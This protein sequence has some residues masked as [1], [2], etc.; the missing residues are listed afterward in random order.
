MRHCI[1]QTSWCGIA[2]TKHFFGN[3]TVSLTSDTS[4]R[5]VWMNHLE[6]SGD[7]V[8]HVTALL[9]PRV[10]V[11]HF[12]K[13]DFTVISDDEGTASFNGIDFKSVTKYQ[14][15]DTGNSSLTAPPRP[16]ATKSLVM[17]SFL[18]DC[19]K[20]SFADYSLQSTGIDSRRRRKRNVTV[21]ENLSTPLPS[22][23]LGRGFSIPFF[24][25]DVGMSENVVSLM[26]SMN[27]HGQACKGSL[28][29][30]RSEV[31][32]KRLA[33]TVR[34]TCSLGK[35]CTLWS[36]G[37][38]RWQ[39]TS[40]VKI[41]PVR[42]V[43]IPDVLYAL[44]VCLTPNTM[45]HSDQ[46]FTSMMLTPPSRNLLKDIIRLVIDPYLTREKDRLIREACFKIREAGISPILCMDVGHSSARNSQA[47]TLAAASGN[48]LL[49]TLTDT[50]T[51]AWLKETSLVERALDFSINVEK[52]DV[53]M[54]EIDDNAKN[55]STISSYTRVN[56]PIE[57]QKEPVKAG[58]DVF[59]AAKAMGKHVI[60]VTGENVRTLE[61]FFK[62]LCKCGFNVADVNMRINEMLLSKTTEFFEDITSAFTK[63]GATAWRGASE[64]PASM[65]ASAEAN[66]L[67]DSTHNFNF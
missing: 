40:E 30:R 31:T 48:V 39:S 5:E 13:E 20:I 14:E 23:L 64:T 10:W 19:R 25:F 34:C 55:A 11:G 17:Q 46:L 42:S 66:N 45:A 7:D 56:G 1:C 26:R 61:K 9:D 38:Y 37:I 67:V 2:R 47:A 41:S 50:K 49:F 18:G 62:P 43:P 57:L 63:F 53:C 24:E 21:N 60:K 59:H 32:T 12:R 8:L 54:V 52:I 16:T 65:R 28:H 15:S 33:L 58:I 44:G 51:N 29:F 4:E 6:I 3:R 36:F 35:G 22:V 27:A